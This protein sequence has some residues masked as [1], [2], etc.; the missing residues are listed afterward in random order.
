MDLEQEIK[1]KFAAK[2]HLVKKPARGCLKHD[3]LVPGGPYSEQ[4]DW[5]AF[6]IGL[7]LMSEL[8]TEAIYLKNWCLNYFDNMRPDGFTPGLL[9]PKGMDVRLNQ[10]KPLLAQGAY[11]ASKF[12]NDFSWIKPHWVKL[13]KITAYR[14]QQHLDKKTGLI[15]WH[16]G[17]ESGADNNVCLLYYPKGTSL[18]TD[19]NAFLYLEYKALSAI[20]KKLD[21]KSDAKKYQKMAKDLAKAMM[22]YMWNDKDKVFYNIDVCTGRQIKRVS[23]ANVIPLWAGL[24]PR[25]R[26]GR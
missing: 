8:S 16:N 14:Q 22:K 4:W 26:V 19:L 11:H 23:H 7:N 20:A 9:T 6:F 13:K 24:L 5:D 1:I 25:R 15:A 12:L 17:M 21:F 2:K 3:Y 18:S 10:M